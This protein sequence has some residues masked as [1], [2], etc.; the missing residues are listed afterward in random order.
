MLDQKR[1][2]YL[3]F[4]QY[5]IYDISGKQESVERQLT[6]ITPKYSHFDC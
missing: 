4:L 2:P 1:E 5:A 3:L 6:K